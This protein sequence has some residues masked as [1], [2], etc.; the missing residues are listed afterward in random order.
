MGLESENENEISMDDYRALAEFR[1]QIR[2]FVHFSE[3]AAHAAGL[4]PQQHQLMLAM[5]GFPDGKSATIS[6]LA[7]RLQLQH[8]STVE[9]IDR[10]V[11][12]SLVAR[13]RGTTDRRQVFVTLTPH[14]ETLLRE[15]SLPHRRELRSA[16][17]DLVRALRSLID[18]RGEAMP[19]PSSHRVGDD[20][21]TPM[22]SIRE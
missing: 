20:A 1:F 9:L 16:G 21:P 6:D 10:S 15:L 22:R 17:P 13:D 3:Q 12:Q 14:G 8:H 19:L 2:R 4:E 11:R 7:E 5:K 18:D